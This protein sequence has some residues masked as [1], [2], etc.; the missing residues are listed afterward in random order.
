MKVCLV[1]IARHENRYLKDFIN[2]YKSIGIDHFIIGDNNDITNDEDIQSLVNELKMN[3][4]VTVINAKKDTTHKMELDIQ[5][6]FYDFAYKEFSQ[7]FDWLCYFDVD[8]YFEVLP[9]FSENNIKEYIKKM[10]QNCESNFNLSPEMIQVGWKI[11]DDNNHLFYEDKPVYERFTNLSN[12]IHHNRMWRN[13]F[14][15]KCIVKSNIP[16]LY[17][18][19][20]HVAS[21]RNHNLITTFNGGENY[22]INNDMGQLFIFK[23]AILKHYYSKSLEEFVTRR[24]FDKTSYTSLDIDHCIEDYFAINERTL[25]KEK[26]IQL[27]IKLLK[28][29]ISHVLT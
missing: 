18:V 21:G 20:M 22:S 26:L 28:N 2:Y 14:C 15:G 10:I 11:Y 5:V 3:D 4:F 19:D 13:V 16:D 8:E 6:E 29:N 17:F 24:L 12:N 23:D 7:Y 27:Y 9:H 25:E 1:C